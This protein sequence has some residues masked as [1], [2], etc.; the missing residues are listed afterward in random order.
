LLKELSATEKPA[1]VKIHILRKWIDANIQIEQQSFQS[2]PGTFQAFEFDR[3]RIAVEMNE[4][5]AQ[6]KTDYV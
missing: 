2:A 4:A 6:W 5:I 3:A 1:L